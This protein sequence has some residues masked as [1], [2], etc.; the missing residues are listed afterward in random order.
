MK[1]ATHARRRCYRNFAK[2]RPSKNAGGAADRIEP[3]DV[4]DADFAGAEN[5]KTCYR[6]KS[7]MGEKR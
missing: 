6:E 2:Y 4:V 3:T 5:K 1:Q 7:Y